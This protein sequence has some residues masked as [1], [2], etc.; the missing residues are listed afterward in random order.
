MMGTFGRAVAGGGNWLYF[1]DGSV[2]PVTDGRALQTPEMVIDDQGTAG[3]RIDYTFTGGVI[4]TRDVEGETYTTVVLDHFGHMAEVGKPAVPQRVYTV[5]VPPGTRAEVELLD[6]DTE[7]AGGYRIHPALEP[8]TDTVGGSEPEFA[9]NQ[10]FYARNVTYPTEPVTIIDTRDLRGTQLA[11]VRICPV[12]YNPALDELTL[13]SRLSFRINFTPRLFSFDAVPSTQSPLLPNI[14]I[15]SSAVNAPQARVMAGEDV[16]SSL[17]IVTNSEFDTAAEALAEWK[18]QMGYTVFLESRSSWTAAQVKSTIHGYTNLDFFVI[19][20]DHDD[21]PSEL[22]GGHVTDLYYACTGGMGD[23]VPDMGYGR[24]SVSSAQEAQTVVDKIIGY[25][26]TPV[27]DPD[28]YTSGM[29]AAYFQHAGSGYAQR[30]FAQTS[31]EIRQ[32]LTGQHGYDIDRIFYTESY[33]NPLYWNNGK[34]SSGEPIPDY[35]RRP[36][37]SWDGNAAQISAGINAGR[38]MVFHRDHG[39][40]TLWGDPYYTT[41]HISQL[42]NGNKLPVVFSINCLTGKFDQN[43]FSEVFLRHTNGGAVGVIGA[44]E[45]SYSGH[46]DGLAEGFVDAIWPDPGLVPLFPHNTSP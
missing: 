18:R 7:I 2:S 46:N 12:Q 8:A 44:T 3:I 38:F 43:S 19:V 30:R 28:F 37:Y 32:Y 42:T 16:F 10:L 41:S 35:L 15:N 6:Y 14:I 25:E 21:V 26:R 29:T 24:I 34:Y 33:V 17:L 39:D 40:L 27:S 31:W 23:F 22:V 45:V 4:N 36:N 1:S 13:Y 20:G 5:A 11:L 9:I